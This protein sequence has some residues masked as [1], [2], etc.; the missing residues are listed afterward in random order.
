M[1][2]IAFCFLIY[3]IINHEDLWNIFFE[4]IDKN[5]YNIYIHY[6]SNTPLKY[7]EEYKLKNCIPTKYEDQTIPLAYN[8]LFRTA[9]NHDNDNYKFIIV[10]GS[11][12]PLKSFNSIYNKLTDNEKGYFNVSPQIQCFPNCNS[13][14]NV[15]KKEH[16]SKSHNWFIL[17]RKLVENLCFQDKDEILDKYYK[18]VWAPAEYFYHTFIKILDLENEIITTPNIASGATTFT[19]WKGM[20]YPYESEYENKN[21]D[22][23]SEEELKYLLKRK[24]LFGRKFTLKCHDSLYNNSFYIDKISSK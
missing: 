24:S 15:I 1:K 10:S 22:S 2:K 14:L 17:N 12:I 5:K 3:D 18:R 20:E 16:I 23:I 19:N 8:L 7:F 9:Y 13:L 6:K 4:N 21:Y 11:C